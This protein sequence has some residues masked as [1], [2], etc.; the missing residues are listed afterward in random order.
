LCFHSYELVLTSVYSQDNEYVNEDTGEVEQGAWRDIEDTEFLF[1]DGTAT[2]PL[3]K[4]TVADANYLSSSIRI[5]GFCLIGLSLFISLGTVGWV[6]VCRESRL[7]K[8]SQPEFLYLLCFGAALVATSLIFIS[9]DESQGFSDDKLSAMCSAFPWFFVIGYLTMYSALFSKLW[10]LSKLLSMR[11]RAV[12]IQQVLLPFC[13]MITATVIILVVWQVVDPLKWVRSKINDDPFETFGECQNDNILPYVILLSV[14]FFVIMA[15][16]A[17]VAWRMKDVQ[18]ELSESKWIFF[19]IIMHIQTWAVG[20]PVVIITEGLSRDAWYI[21]MV[22]LGFIF[23]IS[24]VVLVIWPKVYGWARDKYFSGQPKQSNHVALT[25]PAVS[26]QTTVQVSGLKSSPV[27]S[28][29]LKFVS[30][31]R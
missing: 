3:P 7:V 30:F 29:V 24:L 5:V 14:I 15:M 21:M 27:R 18:A 9:F 19:G 22:S 31:R 11:R 20:I 4:R 2:A 8:A 1:F 6:Y 12:G 13:V 10:R 25:L 16:T 26:G 17:V 23:S 28:K